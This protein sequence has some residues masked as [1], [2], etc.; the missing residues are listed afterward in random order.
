M[1]RIWIAC[2]MTVVLTLLVGILVALLL[3]IVIQFAHS[4]YQLLGDTIKDCIVDT[5]WKGNGY[6]LET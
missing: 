2:K 5:N 1:K 3:I 4:L 6:T